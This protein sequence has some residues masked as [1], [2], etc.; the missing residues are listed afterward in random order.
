[1]PEPS[2]F[3]SLSIIIPTYNRKHLLA[4]ALGGYLAQSLP[5]LIHELLLVD[6]GST[7]GTESL[8]RELSTRSP[9]PIHY[10]RQLNKGPAAARNLGIH[11]ARSN[12][13]LFTDSDIVP[14]ADLVKQHVR[15]HQK[16]PHLSTAV[17][18]YVTWPPEIK[19]TPFMRWYGEG[20]LFEFDRLRTKREASFR[21]FYTCNVSLKTEF[22]RSCGQ[23]DEEFKSA[24]FEDVE[25]GY[26]LSKQGLRL[27]YNSAAVGYHYQF[28]SFED[29]CRKNLGNA[30]AAQLF[31][32]KEA[33]Q[34]DL[35]ETQKRHSR[36][37]YAL[38]KTFAAG[39]ARLLFPARRLLDSTL[40]LPG[41]V[42]YLLLW[43][44][45]R[46]LTHTG[47]KTT[48]HNDEASDSPAP[49]SGR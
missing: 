33:G 35:K 47:A 16:N 18:G 19:A 1:M 27:L 37:S 46:R 39:V 44:S 8:V 22:L 40:P 12:L 7:D 3:N 15:W 36:T 43:D 26:R 30:A 2:L 6:D 10:L 41:F 42:Y 5:Q 20:R 48:S 17:L 32:R 23:F 38:A 49:I 4:K 34:Q 29:A 24:A 14:K 28:F 21:S 11:E 9:F 13:V 45:M 25:L 31:L